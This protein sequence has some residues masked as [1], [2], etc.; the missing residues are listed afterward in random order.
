MIDRLVYSLH[1]CSLERSKRN[2]D[3]NILKRE[4]FTV[5]LGSGCAP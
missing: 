1:E 3:G 4:K 5:P 2:E